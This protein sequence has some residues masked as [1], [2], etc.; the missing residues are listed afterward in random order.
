[1]RE[2]IVQF[3]I[4]Y[5][6]KLTDRLGDGKDGNVFKTKGR[7]AVKFL[8]SEELY[9]REL[10]AYQIL[11]E[12]NIDQIAGFNIPY[13]YR[14]DDPLRAIEMSI[15]QPPFLLDFASAY[16]IDEYNRFE[17]TDDVLGET[18]TKHLEMFDDRWPIVNDLCNAFTRETGL[19][20]LDLSPNNVRFA[21]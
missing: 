20:L 3:E 11:R 10:R 4:K 16:T 21:N 5:A 1:M 19:I 9:R 17:F 13:L 8:I 15:V 14:H 7:R 12:R 18:E 6:T 2:T